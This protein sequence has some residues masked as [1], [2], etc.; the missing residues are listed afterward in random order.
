MIFHIKCRLFSFIEK[1][2]AYY[3]YFVQLND[4]ILFIIIHN[5]LLVSPHFELQRWW[6]C[7]LITKLIF[8]VIT[9]FM[10][11]TTMVVAVTVACFLL[12]NHTSTLVTFLV[13]SLGFITLALF[14]LL[15][16]TLFL[17]APCTVLGISSIQLTIIKDSNHEY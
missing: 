8:A 16:H 12:W 17:V 9:L 15:L 10:A 13:A 2:M 14:V 11:I 7:K 6:I 5:F 4:V 1:G 3:L